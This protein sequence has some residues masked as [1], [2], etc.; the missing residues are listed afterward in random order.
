MHVTGWPD[1]Y[2]ERI[3]VETDDQPLSEASPPAPGIRGRIRRLLRDRTLLLILA[4]ALVLRL[5]FVF[6]GAELYY[7]KGEEYLTHDSFS[8][9]QTAI[10]LVEH[11]EYTHASHQE[12]AAT[13]IV[14]PE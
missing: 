10:N 14:R 13:D 1:S 2:C 12:A 5:L 8:Y 7:G 11:G 6:A 3:S 4:A 9:T